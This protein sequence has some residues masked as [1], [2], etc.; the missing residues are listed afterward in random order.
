MSTQLTHNTTLVEP[1]APLTPA[2][3]KPTRRIVIRK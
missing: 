3:T 2:E 1:P